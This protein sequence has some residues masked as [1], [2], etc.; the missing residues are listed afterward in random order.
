MIALRIAGDLVHTT[1]SDEATLVV[2]HEDF[3]EGTHLEIKVTDEGVIMEMWSDKR[4]EFYNSSHALFEDLGFDEDDEEENTLIVPRW[5]PDSFVHVPVHT[6][7]L[8]LAVSEAKDYLDHTYR[9]DW[10]NA[11]LREGKV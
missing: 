5:A 8:T 2:T 7:D 10:D 4:G 11:V 1:E 6:D 3:P 9:Y